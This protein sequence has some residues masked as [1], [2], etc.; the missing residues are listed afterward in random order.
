M[1]RS[2]EGKRNSVTLIGHIRAD[3]ITAVTQFES[4]TKECW[5]CISAPM[6]NVVQCLLHYV[7]SS[8]N[9]WS[10]KVVIERRDGEE[11]LRRFM[12]PTMP[13]TDI[14]HLPPSTTLFALS[15]TLTNSGQ[16]MISSAHTTGLHTWQH[17]QLFH[18]NIF[19]WIVR[20]ATC[21]GVQT[22]QLG[23][24]TRPKTMTTVTGRQQL[25]IGDAS[26]VNFHLLEFSLNMN[27]KEKKSANRKSQADRYT[28]TGNYHFPESI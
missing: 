4:Q 25:S 18:E 5:W 17:L 15:L 20:L 28:L 8:Q 12:S 26:S 16:S 10:G 23:K 21:E 6:L 9:M 14:A 27:E 3:E 24:H 22:V 2:I 13:T 11:S 7:P 19:V 1:C